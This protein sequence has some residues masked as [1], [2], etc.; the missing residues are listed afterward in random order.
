[1]TSSCYWRAG[2]MR[3][4]LTVAKKYR[5]GPGKT[6]CMGSLS[7]NR[8]SCPIAVQPWFYSRGSCHKSL[9]TA[10]QPWFLS[11]RTTLCNKYCYLLI[12][13]SNKTQLMDNIIYVPKRKFA[14]VVLTAV[15]LVLTNHSLQ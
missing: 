12:K 2:I 9:F 10:V 13:H 8:G 14:A 11:S 4:V 6:T 7:C 1:M 5:K 3:L 15:V